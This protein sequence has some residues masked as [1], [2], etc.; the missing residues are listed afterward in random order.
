MFRNAPTINPYQLHLSSSV[1]NLTKVSVS[2]LGI[3]MTAEGSPVQQQLPPNNTNNKRKGGNKKADGRKPSNFAT[4]CQTFNDRRAYMRGK[5]KTTIPRNLLTFHHNAAA[6]VV[7]AILMEDGNVYLGADSALGK[8]FFSDPVV[9]QRLI[10]LFPTSASVE[11]RRLETQ[12]ERGNYTAVEAALRIACEYQNVPMAKGE[13]NTREVT[14]N[15]GEK[16][17]ESYFTAKID[18]PGHDVF[19]QQQQVT[20]DVEKPAKKRTKTQARPFSKPIETESRAATLAFTLAL[21]NNGRQARLKVKFPDQEW[22]TPDEHMCH[23]STINSIHLLHWRPQFIE[24]KD[25]Q[26]II[27]RYASFLQE[28]PVARSSAPPHQE[29]IQDMPEIKC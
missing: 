26:Q 12:D 27:A 28:Q 5:V 6:T 19:Q 14:G 2:S 11:N 20:V 16:I 25:N 7:Q 23:Y 29:D 9:M 4:N 1:T 8:R 22:H 24:D 18:L 13:V 10:A 3:S 21:W 17:A 15:A